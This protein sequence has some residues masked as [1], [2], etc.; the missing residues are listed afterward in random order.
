MTVTV[1]IVI[2]SNNQSGPNNTRQSPKTSRQGKTLKKTN[3][4]INHRGVSKM[5]VIEWIRLY[6]DE[7]VSTKLKGNIIE[8]AMKDGNKMS[9]D[10]RITDLSFCPFPISHQELS[11]FHKKE[12]YNDD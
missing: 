7:I 8:F 5:K 9:I 3:A 1:E 11:D 10:K 4:R 12:F 2:E 6:N